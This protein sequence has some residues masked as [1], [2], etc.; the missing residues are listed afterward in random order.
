MG[1]EA[2]SNISLFI[3]V[4]NGLAQTVWH[5]RSGAEPAPLC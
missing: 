2:D 1:R 5:Y 4:F 3:F